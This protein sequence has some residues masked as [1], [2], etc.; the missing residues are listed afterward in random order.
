MESLTPEA[1]FAL[2]IARRLNNRSKV[3]QLHDSLQDLLQKNPQN[4]NVKSKAEK[5]LGL[6][7]GLSHLSMKE[8]YEKYQDIEGHPYI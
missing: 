2:Q 5:L 8:I 7:P 4:I 6:L 3:G 1:M